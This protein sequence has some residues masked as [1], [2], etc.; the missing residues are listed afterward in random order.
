M[1]LMRKVDGV[2]GVKLAD[3]VLRDFCSSMHLLKV[4]RL[5]AVRGQAGRWHEIYIVRW[6]SLGGA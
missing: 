4:S 6:I 1:A 3:D 5:N 2:R